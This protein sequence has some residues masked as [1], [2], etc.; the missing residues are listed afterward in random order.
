LK[1]IYLNGVM[2]LNQQGQQMEMGYA[3]RQNQDVNDIAERKYGV[4][5]A[6]YQQQMLNASN[7]KYE[8]GANTND[9]LTELPKLGGIFK[10][11]PDDATI[12]TPAS[13]SIASSTNNKY[14][15][16]LQNPYATGNVLDNS[17]LGGSR[18]SLRSPKLFSVINSFSNPFAQGN[19]LSNSTL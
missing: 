8:L 11:T 17:T 10:T 19:A 1:S 5:A 14:A 6:M 18:A 3:D 2:G 15:Q 12:T 13:T 7:S 4:Q 9:L 16:Y